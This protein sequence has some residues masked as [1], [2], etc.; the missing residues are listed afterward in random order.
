MNKLGVEDNGRV[1]IIIWVNEA[2]NLEELA[3]F[4]FV[5]NF[6]QQKYAPILY[7]KN[8][9]KVF[10]KHLLVQGDRQEYGKVKRPD[11]YCI[12]EYAINQVGLVLFN[13]LLL[14]LRN[15]SFKF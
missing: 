11:D 12:F 7:S 1:W 3:V 9:T 10:G 15:V 13:K 5:V 8:C 14:V 2:L 6:Q 4:V